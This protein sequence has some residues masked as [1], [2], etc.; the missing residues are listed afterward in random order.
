MNHHNNLR[1]NAPRES[2]LLEIPL[3]PRLPRE[4]ILKTQMDPS[5]PLVALCDDAK[6]D[7]A[8]PLGLLTSIVGEVEGKSSTEPTANMEIP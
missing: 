5:N 3:H 2:S 1:R 7:K 8:T 6:K 4:G